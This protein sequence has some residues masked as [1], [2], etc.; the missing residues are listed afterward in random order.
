MTMTEP[1]SNKSEKHIFSE[2]AVDDVSSGRKQSLHSAGEFDFSLISPEDAEFLVSYP[3]K[4]RKRVLRKVSPSASQ[5]V[6][7]SRCLC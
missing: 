4:G 1:E 2:P 3:D 6:S 7:F 5:V